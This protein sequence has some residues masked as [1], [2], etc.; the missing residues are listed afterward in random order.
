MYEDWDKND[1]IWK[2]RELKRD[3]ENLEETVRKLNEKI[4][5]LEFK[6]EHELEPRLR[7]ERNAYDRWVSDPMR[8]G[9]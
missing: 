1:F 6:I 7:A 2:I 8:N 3:K 4:Y 9:E 5:S